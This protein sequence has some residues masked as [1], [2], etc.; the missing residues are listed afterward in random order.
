MHWLAEAASVAMHDGQTGFVVIVQ[1]SYDGAI[2]RTLKR[3]EDR[4]F[5]TSLI[6]GVSIALATAVLWAVVVRSLGRRRKSHKSLAAS[7]MPR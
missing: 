4:L 1:E 5:S 6:A 7:A 2:G 3:L